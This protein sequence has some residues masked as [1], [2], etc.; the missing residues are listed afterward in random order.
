MIPP[1][2]LAALVQG[3][4]VVG[5]ILLF[6]FLG[7]LRPREPERVWGP[8]TW[9]NLANGALLF[10]FRATLMAGLIDAVAGLDLPRPVDLAG[11]RNPW[12]QFTVAFVLQ[13]L[14]RYWMHY[15]HHRVP[16]LWRFHRVHH[17][18]EHM[19]ASSGLRMHVVDFVQLNMIP[20]VLFGLL[21]DCRSFHPTVW[22]GVSVV[23]YAMDA[24]THGNI[25]MDL[26]GPVAR[27]WDTLFVNPC[28]HSWHHARD[29]RKHDGNYG[30]TLAVWDRLFGTHVDEVDPCRDLGLPEDQQLENSLVGLQLLRPK[31]R[32]EERQP[33]T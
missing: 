4:L 28:F 20:V 21:L 17:S 6:L 15:A 13:D 24:W 3:L 5:L 19:N 32:R 16:L 25:A 30:Q 12:L 27:W 14:A 23:V 2:L 10:G 31:V 11:L 1:M 29:W 26:R 8:D 7:W 18:S 22:L 33:R 9:I